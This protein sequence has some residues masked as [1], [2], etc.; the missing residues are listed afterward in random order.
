VGLLPA[1]RWSRAA[2]FVFWSP[3]HSK[4]KFSNVQ[5]VSGHPVLEEAAR[6]AVMQWEYEP[7]LLNGQPVEVVTQVDVSFKLP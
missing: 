4:E 7:I 6:N 1:A 2:I 5:L 3:L